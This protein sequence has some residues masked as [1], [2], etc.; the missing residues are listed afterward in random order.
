L[1]MYWHLATDKC[2]NKSEDQKRRWRNPRI[3]AIGNLVSII[4]DKPLQEITRNDMLR[5]RTW[6]IEP[7][8]TESLTANSANKDLT[9]I[10]GVLRLVN[11]LEG[12][13]LDLP[14]SGMRIKESRANNRPSFSR[15]WITETILAP[16]A[17]DR[18]GHQARII[19]LVLINTG[20]RPSEIANLIA[21]DIIMEHEIP[22]IHIAP[23]ERELKTHNAQRMIPL[24]G[25]SLEAVKECPGGFPRYR[26]KPDL[27]STLNKFMREN[28]LM[29]SSRHVVYSLRHAFEDRLRQARVDDRIRAELFGHAYHRERYGSPS[30]SELADAVSLVAL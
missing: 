7:M 8:A 23:H 14:F 22:H 20:A 27:S 11:D 16:G 5:F 9:H 17:L 18:L 26:D 28:G 13:G 24:V 15:Q 6:W 21:T 29:E 2:V 30:L 10:G 1:E 4:G 3:K 12:L 19:L 25:C